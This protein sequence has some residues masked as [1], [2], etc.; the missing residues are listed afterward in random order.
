MRLKSNQQHVQS[1]CAKNETSK[2]NKQ[3]TY[4][5]FGTLKKF[6]IHGKK[7][8]VSLFVQFI[9]IRVNEMCTPSIEYEPYST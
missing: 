9:Q 3:I 5:F 7:A 4:F 6:E 1:T 2:L 8:V